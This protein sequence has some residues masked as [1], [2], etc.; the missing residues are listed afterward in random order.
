MSV[1]IFEE[2]TILHQIISHL[3][4]PKDI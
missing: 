1:M 4:W 3:L 2:N